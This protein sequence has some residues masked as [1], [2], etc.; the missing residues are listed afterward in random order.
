MILGSCSKLRGLRKLI[1]FPDDVKWPN[2][3]LTSI[4]G[5]ETG[6]DILSTHFNYIERRFGQNELRIKDFAPIINY[7]MSFSNERLHQIVEQSAIKIKDKFEAEIR[8][9]GYYKV[10]TKGCLFICKK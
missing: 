10:T 6:I 7:F 5:A 1:D 2:S 9:Y 3:V 8:Q 4:Y